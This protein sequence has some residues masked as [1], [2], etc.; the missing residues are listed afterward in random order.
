MAPSPVSTFSNLILAGRQTGPQRI[1][2]AATARRLVAYYSAA[3]ALV[4]LVELALPLLASK[5]SRALSPWLERLVF[6]TVTGSY[7]LPQW[8]EAVLAMTAAFVLT[9]P[10]V[11]VYVRTRTEEE[12]D[13]ALVNTVLV[14]PSIV[15]AIL[16]VVQ[17]SLALSFSLAGIVAAVRFRSNVKDSR[18]A[19]YILAGVAIGFAS[20]V[21]ALAVAIAISL[22]FVVLELF[23]WR[24]GVGGDRQHAQALLWGE[25]S[26]GVPEHRGPDGG[27]VAR[28]PLATPAGSQNSRDVVM[29]VETTDVDE[30]THA[31][32][33]V[34]AIHAKKWRLERTTRNGGKTVILEY[35][36]RL[37]RTTTIEAIRAQVLQQGVPF[38]RSARYL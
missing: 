38:I 31:V 16:S 4:I 28:P 29:R 8:L 24:S 5:E 6:G 23:A 7:I 37:R 9:V 2:G 10:A 26:V 3:V 19:L 36:A 11:I 14:L 20:G 1:V 21:H 32:E 25:G 18:D 13:D 17:T 22:S 15:T 30:G 34:L 35:R 27:R 33:H 12:Y